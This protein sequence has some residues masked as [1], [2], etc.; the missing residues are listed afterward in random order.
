M[1]VLLHRLGHSAYRHRKS[2]L[3]I[4]LVVLA[5]LIACVSV[6]GAELDDRFSVPGTESQRALDTLGRTLPD[7]SGADAQIVFTAPEGRHVTDARYTAVI[8]KAVTDAE[9]AP[10]V[11]A[12]V[13]PQDSGAV[14]ADRTTAFVQVQYSVQTA[15][16][17][18]S[19]VHVLEDAARAA[20]QDGLKTSV[21]GSVYGSKGVEVGPS[22]IIG[23]VVAV[24]VLVLTFGSL[25]AAGMSLLAA[26]VG[27]GV[28]LAGLLAL[29]PVADISS[30][31]VTL[32]LMLGLAVGIDYVLFI[33]SRHRQQLA[34]GTE[35]QE[36]MAL[37]TG[38]A[39]SA[40]VFAGTTVIIALAALSVI[41]IPFLT[42]MGLGSAGAVLIAVLAAITLLPALA[43]FAG[44]RLTP[45]PGSRAAKRVLDTVGAGA[46]GGG[47]G[48]DTLGADGGDGG[49]TRGA[50]GARG[51]DTRGAGA[52]D[53]LGARWVKRVVAKPLLT[54]FAVSGVLLTLALPVTDLR[55][56]LPD[57]G[58]AAHGS[59]ERQAY[60]TVNDKFG[61]GFNG[62]LLVLAEA[63]NGSGPQAGAQ[64]AR[65]LRTLKD[66]KAVLPPEPTGDPA[67]SVITVIPASGP[68]SIRTDRLVR[69]IREAGA[70]IRETTGATVAVT[71]TTA[72]NIDISNRL[73]DSLLPFLAIVV[74]LSLLL[75][76]IVFRS[77]IIPVKA[78]VGF[79]LS[80]GAT[81]GVVVALFKWGW[82]ADVLGVPHT[83]PVVSFL[84]IILTGVLFGLAMDYQVFLVSGMR[85]EWIRTR[86]A[87]QSVV[88]GARHS[89]RVVTAAALIMFTVFA[90]FFPLDD[91]LIKPIAFALAVG[92][93][94]DA[95]AVRMTLVPAVLALVGRHAWWLPA[96]L[97]RILPDLDVEGSSLE[98]STPAESGRAKELR[99][100][101]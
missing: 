32:A 18:E 35:P 49:D 55:L 91:P 9:K 17:D 40:V 23:V 70:D 43:G 83:G 95:F 15:E 24:L 31:A 27:V 30:T 78:A 29:A 2:V 98:G 92:V 97:D 88:D 51:G 94:I 68:D 13:A 4:W 22:E 58:S 79:L 25:L 12:V 41:G 5:A 8:A 33:L 19:S 62:P 46:G 54:V 100:V 84:P 1:A 57:N 59:T 38:T 77:L 10:Q 3:A 34:R 45:K 14:S 90:G 96:R 76:M 82:L 47:G 63:E 53:T 42:V 39:G 52:G 71:G 26:L 81:L 86:D 93:V 6:F 60:D 73:S 61:A 28:G 87:R 56:S 80:V 65:K 72:V 99:P 74:G 16:V 85:E 21:G 20:E 50:R 7:A 89:V 11:S 75:L 64:V 101:S 44:A 48:G 66:V 37:A 67:Q 36:S 69:E